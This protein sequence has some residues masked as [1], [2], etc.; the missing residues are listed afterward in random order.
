MENKK[1][2]CK[3]CEAH[4]FSMPYESGHSNSCGYNK[5]DHII[6]CKKCEK[7]KITRGIKSKGVAVVRERQKG[8][9]SGESI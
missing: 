8:F 9:Q 1:R 7:V 3:L 2:M 4:G 6:S 5:N